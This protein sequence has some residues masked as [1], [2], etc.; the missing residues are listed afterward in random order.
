MDWI[1]YVAQTGLEIMAICLSQPPECWHQKHKPL[2]WTLYT[3][4]ANKVFLKHSQ[5]HSDLFWGGVFCFVLE[6]GRE[7]ECSWVKY[8][9][10]NV[11][12]Y[13]W[14][15]VQN[16]TGSEELEEG[17][18]AQIYIFW[19]EFNKI[20]WKLFQKRKKNQITINYVRS[21]QVSQS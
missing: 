16:Q 18:Y 9:N 19:K 1:H 7:K 5:A 11:G 13:R 15:S 8:A 17:K 12:K 14:W 10:S 21:I 2:C 4:S 3:I 6:R 20:I